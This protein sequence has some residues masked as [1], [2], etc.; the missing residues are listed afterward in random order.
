[1]PAA[2]T[3]RAT[4]AARYPTS[5]GFLLAC[6]ADADTCDTPGGDAESVK[7]ECKIAGRLEAALRLLF[8]AAANDPVKTG[9][10]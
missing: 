3:A 9:E 10:T 5:R 2:S 7:R 1:M 6:G 8:E 4:I